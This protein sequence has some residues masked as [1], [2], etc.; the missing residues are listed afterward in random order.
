MKFISFNKYKTY[1]E[2]NGYRL[3]EKVEFS[4]FIS[5]YFIKPNDFNIYIINVFI[6]SDYIMSINYGH[7]SIYNGWYKL[8]I[9]KR[10]KFWKN[11]I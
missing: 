6:N 4:D 1:L 11:M 7:G 3:N 5:Y 9:D 10:T 8:N 2:T